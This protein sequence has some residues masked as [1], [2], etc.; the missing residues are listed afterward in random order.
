[1]R[2]YLAIIKD[3]FREALASRVLWAM[4][5]LSTL[6]LALVVP[7]GIKERTGISLRPNDITDSKGLIEKI[8][9]QEA[10]PQP[11][12]G[13]QIWSLFS[14]G[15]KAELNPTE[16]K[17]P[18]N[19]WPG[20]IYLQL[21]GELQ[22]MLSSRKLY[23]PTAWSGI[24]L[25]QE[26][27]DLIDQD[28]EQLDDEDVQRLNRL[29]LE[30]AYPDE[31]A[32]S[33]ETAVALSYLGKHLFNWP[34]SKKEYVDTA[35][36]WLEWIFCGVIG[37]FAAI[38]VTASI[39]PQTYAAGA[40][41]LLLS[42]PISRSLLYLTKYLGGCMF[43]LLNGAYLIGGLWLIA[44]LRWGQ[45]SH[46]VLF[47]VPILAFIF[48]VYYSVS[49]LAGVIW[50]NAIVS[51]I[52]AVAFWAFCFGLWFVKDFVIDRFFLNPERVVKLVSAGDELV[53]ANERSEILHWSTAKSDWEK[54][55]VGSVAESPP[56][57]PGMM[58]P[59]V[60]PVYDPKNDRLFA[61]PV[62]IPGFAFATSD[63]SLIFGDHQSEWRRESGISAPPGTSTL[64]VNSKGTL[65]AAT[66]SGIMKLVGEPKS[67][68]KP[69]KLFGFDLAAGGGGQFRSASTNLQLGTPLAAAIDRT[70]DE[71]V[72]FDT[73][74]LRLLSPDA[75]DRYVERAQ[76]EVEGNVAGIIAMG[77]GKVLLGQASGKITLFDSHGL[78]PQNEYRPEA[79]T[80]PR[81]ADVSP[82]GKFF[83]VLFH[84]R[85]LWLFDSINQVPISVS[86]TGVGDMSAASFSPNNHL[87][88]A[89]RFTRVT[90]YELP[91]GRV[92]ERW[93]P[94]LGMLE[95]VYF[96]LVKPLYTVFPKPGELDTVVKYL[97]TG[98]ESEAIGPSS[99]L[100]T[101]QRRLDVW[102]PI[103]SNLAFI[104]VV[105]ALGCIY[106]QRKDF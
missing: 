99:D 81:F 45:W 103:W 18:A 30:S 47:M 15:Y 7:F 89:D 27:R 14:D 6:M 28:I 53:A 37:V 8:K 72:L 90:E 77:G 12:P 73:Q 93:R 35:I 13:K 96:F 82:D 21:A 100:Q 102:G 104:G 106:T 1:M 19:P 58:L 105:V 42:K 26:A 67:G 87:L 31:I 70:T 32:S 39:V 71:V 78:E 86:L 17:K 95:K 46:R 60:G 59:L 54:I 48:A 50:R 66:S 40:I 94:T 52:A 97:L 84:N 49:S 56:R 76:R 85:R 2:P 92:V 51:V 5:V 69:V 55:L 79:N 22:E 9:S 88:V 34:S 61:L 98:S 68:K 10:V 3:S 64:F 16:G 91:S 33:R 43:V 4:L 24:E 101:T 57:V 20:M 80:A 63:S 38:L 44:G 62:A 23:D 83:A 11:S 25:S 41:D 74:T 36:N 75:K 29:L 65:L